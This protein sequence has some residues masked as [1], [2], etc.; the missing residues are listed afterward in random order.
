MMVKFLNMLVAFLHYKTRLKCYYDLAEN[1]AK[2]PFLVYSIISQNSNIGI[3]AI[4]HSKN[5]LIQIDIYSKDAK[6]NLAYCDIL[7]NSFC[8]FYKKPF[9]LNIQGLSRDDECYRSIIELEFML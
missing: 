7:E 2:M 3:N 9:A 5:V 4:N 1:E 8:E 6:S